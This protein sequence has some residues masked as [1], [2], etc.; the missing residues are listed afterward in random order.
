MSLFRNNT[1]IIA[2]RNFKEEGPKILLWAAHA[3]RLWR[4]IRKNN[5]N[6]KGTEVDHRGSDSKIYRLVPLDSLS[7]ANCASP[8]E[9]YFYAFCHYLLAACHRWDCPLLLSRG[10]IHFEYSDTNRP[11]ARISKDPEES[12]PSGSQTFFLFSMF[13]RVC[14]S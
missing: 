7:R 9:N 4:G 12:L 6:N 1:T 2:S 14:F 5:N 3:E 8:R 11:R 13:A 10:G